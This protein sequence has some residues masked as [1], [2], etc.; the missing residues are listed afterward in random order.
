ME[1]AQKMRCQKV[2]F[3][4]AVFQSYFEVENSKLETK[5]EEI[6]FLFSNNSTLNV[7][8]VFAINYDQNIFQVFG[9][10]LIN[11][12]LIRPFVADPFH[13]PI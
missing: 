3:E 11:A 2:K 9:M 4:L 7:E 6:E 12:L 5:F 13:A 1:V 8:I 10:F